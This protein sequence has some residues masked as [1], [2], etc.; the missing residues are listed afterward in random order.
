MSNKIEILNSEVS[1][2]DNI[3]NSIKMAIIKG[4]LKPGQPISQKEVAEV[5]GVS[6]IPVREAFAKLEG[7]GF[8]EQRMNSRYY[9]QA[10]SKSELIDLYETRLIL[11]IEGIK[12][13]FPHYSQMDLISLE[14][15]LEKMEYVENNMEYIMLNTEFHKTLI[16]KCPNKQIVTFIRQLW[17]GIALYSPTILT[18][19]S[20]FPND[21]HRAILNAIKEKNVDQLVTDYKNHIIQAQKKLFGYLN[22]N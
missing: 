10:F 16:D 7:T 15:L 22:I 17:D 18:D 14:S 8:I 12:L 2:S 9:V 20:Q 21:E 5:F 4:R 3:F 11:E 13:A 19:K 6:R 1:L